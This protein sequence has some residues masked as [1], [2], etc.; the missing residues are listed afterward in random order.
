MTDTSPVII[1]NR[2]LRWWSDSEL[3][4]RLL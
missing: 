3:L 4:S 2:A 1:Y